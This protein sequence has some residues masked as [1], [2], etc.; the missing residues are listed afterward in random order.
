MEY[1]NIDG[2]M[3]P[4]VTNKQGKPIDGWFDFFI[5]YD[6]MIAKF[7]NATFLEVGT[8]KG[9]ST[10]YMADRIRN[11]GKNIKLYAID[12]F[13]EFVSQAKQEDSSNIYME[14]L[15][16]IEPYIDIVI[17][18]KGDS[19]L[20]HKEFA[21][22]T[23]DFIFIDGGHD[24]ETVIEDIKG[25]YPKLKDGGVIGGHD[26]DWLGVNKAVKEFFG[27]KF[28][29]RGITWLVNHK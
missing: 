8:W 9:R 4:N 2:I 27:D 16:N 24:Y 22:K 13:G 14:F 7:D 28:I 19:T 17:P 21:D 10:V 15:N 20:L 26:I 11:S 12:I 1:K 3:W 23:F 6:E 18:I 29:I 25:W 5:L